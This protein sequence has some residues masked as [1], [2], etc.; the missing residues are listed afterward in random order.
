M[1]L[2]HLADIIPNLQAICPPDRRPDALIISPLPNLRLEPGAAIAEFV[3]HPQLEAANASGLVGGAT[4]RRRGE[5]LHVSVTADRPVHIGLRRRQSAEYEGGNCSSEL[6]LIVTACGGSCPGHISSANFHLSEQHSCAVLAEA[7]LGQTSLKQ[8]EGLSPASLL[9][10]PTS[11]WSATRDS[12]P[13]S[14]RGD[15]ASEPPRPQL[16][17]A[18]VLTTARAISDHAYFL[19]R[20]KDEIC[21]ALRAQEPGVASRHVQI[22]TLMAR[23]L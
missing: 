6:L 22:A 8:L 4:V 5:E 19:R 18:D 2:T 3:H 15:P 23:R 14:T 13:G 20:V 11:C 12:S 10:L 7:D 16:V 21:A 17:L 1:R 9:G